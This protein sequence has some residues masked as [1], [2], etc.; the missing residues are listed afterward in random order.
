[1]FNWLFRK[2]EKR[3]RE[4]TYVCKHCKLTCETC[5]TMFCYSRLP[6]NNI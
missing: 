6:H 1:M 5:T 4:K 3:K 2:K